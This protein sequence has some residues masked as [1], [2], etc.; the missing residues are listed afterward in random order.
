[1]K[2]WYMLILAASTLLACNK[3]EDNPPVYDHPE[4]HYTDLLDQEVKPGE[5]Q[6]LDLDHDG[7][8]DFAFSTWL[9]GDPIEKEDEV[10]FFAA[11]STHSHLLADD[12][13]GSP[14][15]NAG[16]L[17]KTTAISGHGWYAVAQVELA[18]KNTPENGPV[19]WE[20]QWKEARGKFLAV[21]VKENAKLY[22]GWIKLSFDTATGAI[23]LHEAALSK[24]EGRNV[25]AGET[26]Q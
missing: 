26:G 8:T 3:N 5:S 15:Y 9:I 21:Q 25:I 23:I 11:S 19:Y 1:M 7:T 24:E 14:R 4:M 6:L 20:G 12:A 17:I 13:N 16:D 2:S 18:M 10:L 22:N